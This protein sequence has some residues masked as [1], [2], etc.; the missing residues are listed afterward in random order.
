MAEPEAP[1]APEADQPEAPT[2]EQLNTELE[3][4]RQQLVASGWAPPNQPANVIQA[5]ARVMLELPGIGKTNQSEQGYNYRGIEA[6]TA[7]A[8]Q[9]LGRYC[10]V[11]VPRVVERKTVEF[12]IN[13][14]PWTEDQATIIYTVYGP[15]GV[16]DKIEVGPLIALGR[17]NS[18]KG[19]NKCMTQAF[20]YAL[21][22]TLCI[23]DHKDDADGEEAHQADARPEQVSPERQARIDLAARI[24]KLSPEGRDQVRAFC[25]EHEIPRVPAQFDDEQLERVTERVDAIEIA[26]AQDAAAEATDEPPTP[27]PEEDPG[28]GHLP[29]DTPAPAP[30]EQPEVEQPPVD[31]EARQLLMQA[32]S[33]Q[34]MKLEGDDLNA[35]CRDLELSIMGT[36]DAKRRRWVDAM[37]ERTLAEQAAGDTTPTEA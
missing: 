13:N 5:L 2:D 37:V 22:Q 27:A 31:D 20:K 19:M 17:D 4:L 34:A 9:L 33:A 29:L 18:D 16:E 26:T 14:R 12:S 7:H 21:L 1:A 10:V 8:Q 11:F 30:E 23:G 28:D 3:A 25:D 24:R 6:I 36:N 15:G 32:L 35:A